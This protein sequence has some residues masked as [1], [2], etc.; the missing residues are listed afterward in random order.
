MCVVSGYSVSTL[1]SQ[2]R[3]TTSV[4][5]KYQGYDA[6]IDS[7]EIILRR[8]ANVRLNKSGDWGQEQK[9][10]FSITSTRQ[11]TGRD[12]KYSSEKK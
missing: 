9:W 11:I 5:T 3:D 7:Q 4:G 10:Q 2:T 6:V 12:C 1:C 8:K